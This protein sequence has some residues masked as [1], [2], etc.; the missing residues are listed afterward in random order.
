MI[1]CIYWTIIK[2][3]NANNE[4]K[5]FKK[6]ISFKNIFLYIVYQHTLNV[7]TKIFNCHLCDQSFHLKIT[8]EKKKLIFQL[9]INSLVS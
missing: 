1:D 8:L 2:M 9:L 7:F 6:S 3:I 4:T 5:L